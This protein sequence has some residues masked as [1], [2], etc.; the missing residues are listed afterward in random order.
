M[1]SITIERCI[2]VEQSGW[3]LLRQALW[4]RSDT[5][6]LKE[7]CRIV[8]QSE[9]CASLVAYSSGR[10]PIGLAEISVRY[11]HVNGASGSPV[12]FLEG[13]YV[14]PEFRRRQIASRLV[15]AA[16]EWAIL[17]GMTEIVSDTTVD[18]EVSQAL[19]RALGFTEVGRL[20][21]FRKSLI[22]D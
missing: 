10:Q 2:T 19:H 15:E 8:A 1:S 5:E 4:P 17:K 16:I 13:L 6:H 3:L 22:K 9:R 14:V 21:Y 12:A 20:V 7:M 18:N 11:E